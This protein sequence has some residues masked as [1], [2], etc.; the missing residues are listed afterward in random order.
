MTLA[1]QNG[2]SRFGLIPYLYTHNVL[3]FRF[4]AHKI[5]QPFLNFGRVKGK[6]EN[7]I[8]LM[9]HGNLKRKQELD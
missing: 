8:I 7:L 5:Q 6:I 4:G 9:S 2:T 1:L 3:I